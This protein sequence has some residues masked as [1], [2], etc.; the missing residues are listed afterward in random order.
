MPSLMPAG[1]PAPSD[2]SLPE[3]ARSEVALRPLGIYIHVPFCATR[4]GYCDFNTY[5]AAELGSEPGASRASYVDAA[6]EEI[7]LAARVLGSDAPMISTIF[8]GGGTPTVLPPDD[9]GRLVTAVRD[10][11]GLAEYSEL[12]TE[13]NP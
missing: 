13:S 12:T 2:G 7:E 5:T 11:L 10:R 4:C 3:Q 8:V 1:Q 9:L 6:I